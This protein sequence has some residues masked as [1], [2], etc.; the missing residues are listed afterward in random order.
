MLEIEL[1]SNGS[2]SVARESFVQ[3]RPLYFV[4]YHA[5]SHSQPINPSN[6]NVV[7]GVICINCLSSSTLVAVLQSEQEQFKTVGITCRSWLGLITEFL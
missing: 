4:S 1:F 3:I 5:R 2:K 6:E 7:E